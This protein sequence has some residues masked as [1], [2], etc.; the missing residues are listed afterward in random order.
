LPFRRNRFLSHHAGGSEGNYGDK[1]QSVLG[2]IARVGDL[3]VRTYSIDGYERQGTK[4]YWWG[5][6]DAVDTYGAQ[7]DAPYFQDWGKFGYPFY[8]VILGRERFV[9][10]GRWF[11]ARQVECCGD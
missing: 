5:H 7:K 4:I 11:I 1:P 3:Q 10:I 2:T 9:T 6:I 8:V